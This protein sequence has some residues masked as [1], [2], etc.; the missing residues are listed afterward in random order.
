LVNILPPI[1]SKILILALLCA[2]FCFLSSSWA[3]QAIIPERFK[4]IILNAPEPSYPPAIERILIRAQGVYRL[5]INQ[6][7]GTVEE[8]G[9]LKRTS[10]SRLDAE[11]VMTF[12]K[13]TFR[14]GTISQLEVPV[15]FERQVRVLLKNA[16][17]K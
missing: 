5:K 4:G 9:V 7:T 2:Q 14:P 17:S 13:W 6:K 11:C 3:D 10:H 16:G 12:F 8:V 1:Q 15:V